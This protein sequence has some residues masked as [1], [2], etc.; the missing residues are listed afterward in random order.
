[1]CAPQQWTRLLIVADL[2]FLICKPNFRASTDAFSILS[3]I[4]ID[5]D[6]ANWD[7]FSFY[8]SSFIAA[9]FEGHH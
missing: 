1:M 5:D 3:D 2:L 8:F 4:E 7:F 6:F 9:V